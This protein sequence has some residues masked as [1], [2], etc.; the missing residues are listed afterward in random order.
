[1]LANK[2]LKNVK[3]NFTRIYLIFFILGIYIILLAIF[4][5]L[6][7][8][9]TNTKVPT[10]KD[11]DSNVPKINIFEE[12]NDMILDKLINFFDSRLTNLS[13]KERELKLEELKLKLKLNLEKINDEINIDSDLDMIEI[14]KLFPKLNIDDLNSE[15]SLLQSNKTIQSFKSNKMLVLITCGMIFLTLLVIFLIFCLYAPSLR[16]YIY[17]VVY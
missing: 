12:T 13:G 6:A 5:K 9:V 4:I 3:N 7:L 11:L 1:M 8:D 15:I 17:S 2:M 14:D 10:L 16:P